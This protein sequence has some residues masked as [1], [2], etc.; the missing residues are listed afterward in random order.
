LFINICIIDYKQDKNKTI[1]DNIEIIED[2]TINIDSSNSE[3]LIIPTP[4]PLEAAC[5]SKNQPITNKKQ[6]KSKLE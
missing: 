5:Q 4:T 3:L 1:C 2:T 6:N